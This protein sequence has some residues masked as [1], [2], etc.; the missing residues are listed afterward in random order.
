MGMEE[1][2]DWGK[3][4][5]LGGGGFNHESR[6][7]TRMIEGLGLGRFSNRESYEMNETWLRG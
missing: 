4:G 6:E 5:E 3:G 1:W 7:F 2:L